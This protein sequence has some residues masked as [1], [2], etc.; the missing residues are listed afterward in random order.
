MITRVA[1]TAIASRGASTS[2]TISHAGGSCDSAFVFIDRVVAVDVT[3]MTYDGVAMTRLGVVTDANNHIHSIWGV[4]DCLSGTKDVIITAPSSEVLRAGVVTYKGVHRTATFPNVVNTGLNNGVPPLSVAVTTTVNNC[5]L[6]GLGGH[7]GSA[8]TAVQAGT[9]TIEVTAGDYA[10]SSDGVYESNPTDTGASGSKS[11][12]VS[13]GSNA[14][15]LSLIVV[16]IA[17]NNTTGGISSP[18][19]I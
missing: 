19:I 18:M 15:D 2:Y 12:E 3:S 1:T 4:Q 16:A 11:L 13:S 17:P 9:G 7:N 14:Q 8:A 5:T 10:G 6:L